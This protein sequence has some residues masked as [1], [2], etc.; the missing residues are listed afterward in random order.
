MARVFGGVLMGIAGIA[1]LVE[2]YSHRPVWTAKYS[3]EGF[4][5]PASGLPQIAYDML[6]IGGWALLIVGVLLVI[7]GLVAYARCTR[8]PSVLG[9]SR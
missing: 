8:A 2:A 6:R 9:P 7:I 5:E 3:R 4:L 1:A